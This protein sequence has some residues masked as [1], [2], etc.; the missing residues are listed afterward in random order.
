MLNKWI[1]RFGPIKYT[2]GI[3]PKFPIKAPTFEIDITIDVSCIFNGPIANELFP[4]C[5]SFK[6]IVGHQFTILKMN[7]SCRPTTKINSSNLIS[8]QQ[9]FINRELTTNYCY[10]LPNNWRHF[11]QL[12]HSIKKLIIFFILC[13][14]CVI[15]YLSQQRMMRVQTHRGFKKIKQYTNRTLWKQLNISEEIQAFWPYSTFQTDMK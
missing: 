3:T 8:K 7:G 13:I 6:L 4:S 9:H 12:R 14:F 2:N 1:V 11:E 10:E 15:I 5:R